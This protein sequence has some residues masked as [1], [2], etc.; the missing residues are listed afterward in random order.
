MPTLRQRL[1]MAEFADRREDATNVVGPVG[2]RIKAV[3]G[4]D[5]LERI[6]ENEG[7]QAVGR[8]RY[9]TMLAG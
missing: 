6:A 4:E 3:E 8:S 1:R 5:G 9:Y 2:Q 7:R